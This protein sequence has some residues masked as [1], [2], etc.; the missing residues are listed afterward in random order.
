MTNNLKVS[1]ETVRGW[2]WW[3]LCF[4]DY[5]DVAISAVVG[6]GFKVALV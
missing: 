2:P 5:S 1:R 4:L 3:C 6:L